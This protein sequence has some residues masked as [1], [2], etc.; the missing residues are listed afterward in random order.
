MKHNLHMIL[1]ELALKIFMKN[2]GDT[3]EGDLRIKGNL[4]ID[5]DTT[6]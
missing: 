1:V 5:G 2:S 6:R 4:I 3:I